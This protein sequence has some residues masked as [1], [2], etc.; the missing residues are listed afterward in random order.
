ML[1]YKKEGQT[2]GIANKVG[3]E[4]KQKGITKSKACK[5]HFLH[6]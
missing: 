6:I 2:I 1:G 4:S 5:K 3:Y